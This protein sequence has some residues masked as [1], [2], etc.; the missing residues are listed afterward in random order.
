MLRACL[1][2]QFLAK[3]S[4]GT[5][6]TPLNRHIVTL[7]PALTLAG[8]RCISGLRAR[9]WPVW[10]PTT[11]ESLLSSFDRTRTRRFILLSIALVDCN[12]RPLTYD[13]LLQPAITSDLFI[14][15]ACHLW[16]QASKVLEPGR[17]HAAGPPCRVRCQVL[18]AATARRAVR[19][20]WERQQNLC[21]CKQWSDLCF[22]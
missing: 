18:G 11:A 6:H 21:W 8:W 16:H 5:S 22:R 2:K 20:V 12:H 15:A 3:P 10:M 1:C 13:Y 4:T 9:C 14:I 7:W 17:L 19:C